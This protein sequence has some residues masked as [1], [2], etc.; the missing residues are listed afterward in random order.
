LRL[1]GSGRSLAK[2]KKTRPAKGSRR[3]SKL[4][5]YESRVSVRFWPLTDTRM[6]ATSVKRITKPHLNRMN[7]NLA[8]VCHTCGGRTNCRVGVS[9]QPEVP[10]HFNCPHCGAAIQICLE[11]S[12]RGVEGAEQLKGRSHFDEDTPFVDLHLDFPVLA[13]K[14]VMGMTPFMRARELIGDKNLLFHTGRLS[15]LAKAHS[16]AAL[17]RTLLKLYEKGK[18]T[19]FRTNLEREFGIKLRSDKPEDLNSALF[20]LLA[21]VMHPF[22]LPEMGRAVVDLYL[23]TLEALGKSN[24][25]AL[26]AF[27]DQIVD[28]DF[29][30]NLHRDCLEIYPRILD[31]QLPLR[32]A[33]FMDFM[34]DG[35]L[36]AA[37][38]RVSTATFASVKDIFKD[39]SEVISRLYVLIAGVNNLLKRGNHNLFLPGIG[40]IKGGRDFTPKN[41]NGF[42]DVDFGRKQQY[43]DD[44]WYTMLEGAVSNRMRNAI[45]HNKAE[46]DEVHQVVTYFPSKE[47]MGQEVSSTVSFLGFLHWVLLA[48]REMRRMHHLVKA[49][50]Y[51]RY[52]IQKKG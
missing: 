21:I 49:L 18:V 22:E 42:A 33:L 47:G 44:P 32:A 26:D 36:E 48:Y 31:L 41:L 13:G 20:D 10:L 12:S 28:N 14:Y 11:G 6:T 51:F 3:D 15:R 35:A 19:P 17:F 46:Y 40:Q 25:A 50:Y 27:V 43:V 8:V 5:P 34:A 4:R 29:L 16:Q 30:D 1:N 9:S 23:S 45:A 37:P 39:I 24:R 7:I 2:P 52:L 38:M